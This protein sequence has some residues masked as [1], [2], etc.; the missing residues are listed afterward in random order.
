MDRRF[1]K[2]RSNSWIRAERLF[3]YTLKNMPMTYGR[4]SR[5]ISFFGDDQF[6]ARFCK[7]VCFAKTHRTPIA[8]CR[9]V[10]VPYRC[11]CPTDRMSD[12]G[13]CGVRLFQAVTDPASCNA[14]RR[15]LHI[16]FL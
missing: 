5:A 15:R 4:S 2:G 1:R 12:G 11:V 13:I 7:L 8:Q 9:I 14:S 16:E 6:F 3:A 10:G